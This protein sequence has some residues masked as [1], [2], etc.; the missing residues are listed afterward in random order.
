LI[1]V[2]ALFIKA[3]NGWINAYRLAVDLKRARSAELSSVQ[4]DPRLSK[5][6]N[7]PDDCAMAIGNFLCTLDMLIMLKLGLQ[8]KPNNELPNKDAVAYYRLYASESPFP[9]LLEVMSE[10]I[11]D[12]DITG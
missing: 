3:T 11:R 6:D 7:S 4:P 8:F 12:N 2:N 9:S 1:G 10:S 5:P